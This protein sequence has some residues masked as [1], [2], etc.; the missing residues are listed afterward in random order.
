[1]I[2]HTHDTVIPPAYTD[3]SRS[4]PLADGLM[5]AK[6]RRREQMLKV[7]CKAKSF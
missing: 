4:D 7:I 5:E 2:A 3:D 1:M 6:R